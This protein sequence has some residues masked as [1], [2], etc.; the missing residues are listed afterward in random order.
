MS[1]ETILT[2]CRE[3]AFRLPA[4]TLVLLGFCA[5]LLGGCSSL[6]ERGPST[7][8]SATVLPQT[9]DPSLRKALDLALAQRGR[10]YRN[11][12]DTP[13]GFDCSGL[14]SY[15]YGNAGYT[16]PRSAS[17]Q[18]NATRRVPK[19]KLEVGDLVFFKL[20]GSRISHVGIFLGG[21]KFL[22][23]P[24]SGKRVEVARMSDPYWHK[25]YVGAGR[26]DAPAGSTFASLR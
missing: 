23:A 14:V 10:P 15:A 24:S 4:R 12:G 3:T 9:A 1:R 2:P 18:F 20:R 16:L 21:D 19:G 6:G 13:A 8:S 7:S 5:L 22:H 26:V 17:D 25:R 11:G